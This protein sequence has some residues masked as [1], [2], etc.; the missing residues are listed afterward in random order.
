MKIAEQVLK[1]RKKIAFIY[2]ERNM[3]DKYV[4]ALNA[5]IEERF[6]KEHRIDSY[7]LQ[8]ST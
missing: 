2:L 5:A 8:L 1:D 4:K 6:D 7:I 3:A